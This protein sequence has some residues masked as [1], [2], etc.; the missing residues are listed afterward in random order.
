M[1]MCNVKEKLLV[2]QQWFIGA[3]QIC[4]KYIIYTDKQ[5]EKNQSY[6]LTKGVKHL[7]D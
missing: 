1:V 5:V 6:N 7:K 4:T 3:I 2:Y